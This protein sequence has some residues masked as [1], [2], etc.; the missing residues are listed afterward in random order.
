[1]P[2]FNPL[3]ILSP[4]RCISGRII[5]WHLK[6]IH[7]GDPEAI[8]FGSIILVSVIGFWAVV[9]VPRNF[10]NFLPG[11]AINPL[12]SIQICSKSDMVEIICRVVNVLKDHDI[13][14]NACL[15]M[16]M[17]VWV[18]LSDSSRRDSLIH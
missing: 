12:T 15:W 5:S 3:D 14:R 18:S 4:D 10:L 7:V 17:G 11:Q 2:H 6:S 16:F 8:V 1:M 13:A 9:A